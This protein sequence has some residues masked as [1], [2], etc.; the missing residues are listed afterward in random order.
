ML[1]QLT[2]V[3]KIEVS[4]K[5]QLIEEDPD[6]NKFVDCAISA[7]VKYVVSNDRHFNILK[8]IPF[9]KVDIVSIQEFLSEVKKLQ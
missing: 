4:Y 5:W 6:D 9:P 3:H 2:N 1:V 7:R 8:K